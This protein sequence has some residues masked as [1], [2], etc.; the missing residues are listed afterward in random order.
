MGPAVL[1]VQNDR[2][3]TFIELLIALSILSLGMLAAVSMHLGSS[4]NNAKGNIYTQA[5]MLAKTQLENL[6]N[7]GVDAL[8]AGGGTIP[9]PNN[10]IDA[11]GQPGGIY[12]RSWTIDTLGT[13]ARR[14]TVTVQWTRRGQPGN[15]VLSSNTRGGGV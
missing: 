13:G 8:V 11:N 12:T 14:I 5:N 7:R 6:K 9:D 15:V 3:F 4:R 1:N 2:G 10:P